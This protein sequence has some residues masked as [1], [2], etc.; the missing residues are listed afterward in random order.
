MCQFL[1]KPYFSDFRVK[2]P[3]QMVTVYYSSVLS[4]KKN[5]F[6]TVERIGRFAYANGMLHILDKKV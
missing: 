6:E 1:I 5:T 2:N 3:N 4:N